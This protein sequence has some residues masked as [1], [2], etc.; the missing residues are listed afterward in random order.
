MRSAN[1]H[2]TRPSVIADSTADKAYNALTSPAMKLEINS[3]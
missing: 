2:K 3:A 1:A